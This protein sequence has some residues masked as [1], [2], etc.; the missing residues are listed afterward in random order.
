MPTFQREHQ[1]AVGAHNLYQRPTLSPVPS[2]AGFAADPRQGIIDALGRARENTLSTVENL[3]RQIASDKAHGYETARTGERQA[4]EGFRTGE[5]G[6]RQNINEAVSGFQR[7]RDEKLSGLTRAIAQAQAQY[8]EKDVTRGIEE[9]DERNRMKALF[10]TLGTLAGSQFT[11]AAT[12]YGAFT[13]AARDRIRQERTASE[14]ANLEEQARERG[15]YGER[16]GQLY[17]KGS[18][19]VRNLGEQLLASLATIQSS[20]DRANREAAIR[21]QEAG[22]KGA[23]GITGLDLQSLQALEGFTESDRTAALREREL[24]L[25]AQ[26]EPDSSKMLRDAIALA[27]LTG[28]YTDPFTGARQPTL[29]ATRERRTAQQQQRDYVSDRI[30]AREEAI[31]KTR[32]TPITHVQQ[33]EAALS[34]ADRNRART[35][36]AQFLQPSPERQARGTFAKPFNLLFRRGLKRTP[37]EINQFIAQIAGGTGGDA[38]QLRRELASYASRQLGITGISGTVPERPEQTSIL[39]EYNDLKDAGGLP[40]I[41]T[42]GNTTRHVPTLSEYVQYKQALTA[43]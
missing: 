33:R 19:G 13:Q 27:G 15:F 21:A 9:Q 1:E 8:G 12:R 18:E 34:A 24:E 10:G 32:G 37:E 30:R 20:E 40:M 36:L 39:R 23:E 38:A 2:A 16:V 31:S 29:E 22:L 14:T 11:D 5:T 25:R 28:M 7:A 4:R 41:S 26:Q 42:P 6:I 35:L 17:E 3:Y 43:G